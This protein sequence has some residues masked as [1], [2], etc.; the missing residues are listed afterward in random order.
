MSLFRSAGRAATGLA[1][2]LVSTTPSRAQQPTQTPVGPQWLNA[3]TSKKVNQSNFRALEEWST[4]N[5]YR[6]RKSV[7]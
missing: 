6:D 2:V 3:D 7:V 1:L 5:E 4:P